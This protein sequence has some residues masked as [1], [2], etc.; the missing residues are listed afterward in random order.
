MVK[1]S[2]KIYLRDCING[3]EVQLKSEFSTHHGKAFHNINT[4]ENIA[5]TVCLRFFLIKICFT[6]A[7]HSFYFR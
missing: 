3:A 4:E 1:P 5:Y 6:E 7:K 2:L